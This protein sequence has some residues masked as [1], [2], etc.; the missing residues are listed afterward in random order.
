MQAT[1]FEPAPP[2]RLVPETSALDRSATLAC[3]EWVEGGRVQTVWLGS[4]LRSCWRRLVAGSWLAGRL[5][6]GGGVG[7]ELAGGVGGELAGGVGGELAGG[8]GGELAGELAGGV[9]GELAGGVGGELGGSWVGVGWELAGSWRGVVGGELAGG[10]W[11]GVGGELAGGGWRGVGGGWLAGSWRGVVGGEWLAGGGWRGVVHVAILATYAVRVQERVFMSRRIPPGKGVQVPAAALSSLLPDFEQT[12][13]VDLAAFVQDRRVL[14][15]AVC[16]LWQG[17][18]TTAEFA[19]QTTRC[20]PHSQL[21]PS[22]SSS[23]CLAVYFMLRES[24]GGGVQNQVLAA[25]YWP[26]AL[27]AVRQ[28]Q[29]RKFSLITDTPLAFRPGSSRIPVKCDITVIRHI[30]W[31]GHVHPLAIKRAG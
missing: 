6:V 9:G 15:E 30:E 11:R 14:I 12:V 19:K 4:W 31:V 23:S 29:D 28:G 27:L 10:G 17:F 24:S 5:G 2:K 3:S 13:E 22:T 7:G 18:S 25:T 1:G 8:V 21:Q 26:N 20:A 16:K